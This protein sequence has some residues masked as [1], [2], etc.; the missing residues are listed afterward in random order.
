MALPNILKNFNLF[1]DG[2]SLMGVAEEIV[3]PKLARKME[4][5]QGGGMPIPIDIDLGNQKIEFDWTCA[6][7]V[8]DLVKQYGA[9]KASA[10]LLRFAGAYQ[11]DDTEAVQAVE[12]VVRGRH[13]EMDFG[14]QKIGSANKTKI[15]TTCSYYKLTVDGTVL[16]EID[17]PAMIFI[18]DGVDMMDAQ[19][20]AIGL[21]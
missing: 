5:Y 20:K 3:L 14:S 12:I 13:S 2:E 9:S 11:R 7:S 8:F 18:V 1:T 10:K 21:A 16:I 15:K 19:R 17:G 6:G 4:E